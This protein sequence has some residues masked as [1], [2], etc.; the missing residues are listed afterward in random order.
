[1]RSVTSCILGPWA[2]VSCSGPLRATLPTKVVTMSMY[3]IP[4]TLSFMMWL[5][6]MVATPGTDMIPTTNGFGILCGTLLV[7]DLFLDMLSSPE[8]WESVLHIRQLLT[9][10]RQGGFLWGGCC[11]QLFGVRDSN[12]PF[13]PVA[14]P[15]FWTSWWT[16]ICLAATMGQDRCN[17]FS[18]PRNLGDLLSTA[19][20]LATPTIASL[21]GS[22][23]CCGTLGISFLSWYGGHV[24]WRNHAFKHLLSCK[25][26]GNTSSLLAAPLYSLPTDVASLQQV[27]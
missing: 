1:M 17:T 11:L 18:Q 27:G 4:V 9:L 26:R 2:R 19:G 22:G 16:R 8:N 15:Q 23:R 24:L 3:V 13:F 7:V 12:H 25:G 21:R 14:E 5:V 10:C 6:L 20:S